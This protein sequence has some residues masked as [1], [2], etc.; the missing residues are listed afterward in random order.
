MKEQPRKFPYEDQI[1]NS[2]SLLLRY[3]VMSRYI[4]VILRFITSR[5]NGFVSLFRY[6]RYT[7]VIFRYRSLI[8]NHRITGVMLQGHLWAWTGNLR[9]L[10]YDYHVWVFGARAQ[11]SADETIFVP[12]Q[13]LEIRMLLVAY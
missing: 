3:F 10:V 1:M 7:F 5:E 2:A 6:F 13:I 9:G 4:F 11:G 12:Q 8:G